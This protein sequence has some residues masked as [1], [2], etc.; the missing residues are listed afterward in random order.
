MSV[1]NFTHKS[2]FIFGSNL[3]D[4]NSIYYVQST[5]LPGLS[6]NH[7]STSTRSMSLNFQGDTLVFNDLNL[8]IILDEELNTWKDIVNTIFKM[9]KDGVGTLADQ[10]SWLEIHDDNSNLILKLFFHGSLI[11]SIGDVE[12]ESNSEDDILTL[13]LTIKYNFYSIET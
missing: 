11:E 9:R 2:N 6:L 10:T 8:N 1:R 13:P 12:Y 7:I 3:L 5:N 4:E